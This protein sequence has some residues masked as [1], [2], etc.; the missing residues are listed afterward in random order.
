MFA[1]MQQM[2]G[3]NMMQTAA[4]GVQDMGNGRQPSLNGAPPGMD[5]RVAS[6]EQLMPGTTGA[7]PSATAG[8][9]STGPRPGAMS[10]EDARL[11]DIGLVRG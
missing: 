5:P 7:Q 6:V 3:G 8:I 11:A 1:F 9:N 10:E 2:G 4:A